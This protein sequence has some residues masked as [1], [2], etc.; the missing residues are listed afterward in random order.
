[1]IGGGKCFQIVRA[2][3]QIEGLWKSSGVFRSLMLVSARVKCAQLEQGERTPSPGGV[4]PV[5][6]A[7]ID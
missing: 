3:L 2:S 4:W 7:G 1:M 5:L 6:F